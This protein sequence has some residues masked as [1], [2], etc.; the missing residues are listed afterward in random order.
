MKKFLSEP[1]IHFL[2]IGVLLFLGFSF[3]QK[4]DQSM[5]ATI[6]ITDN[7][8]NLLM[9]DF[10]RTW[11]RPP[12]EKELQGLL[13]EKIRE[14]IAYREGLALGLDRDDPYIRRRLRMKLELMLED[15]SAQGEVTDEQLEGFL[16]ENRPSFRQEPRLRFSQIY[17]NPDTRAGTLESD[18][19]DLLIRLRQMGD[20]LNL[21][22]FGDSIML[23][24]TF[25][26][27]SESVINRQFGSD[28]TEQLGRLEVGT[29]QGPVPSGYGIHLVLVEERSEGRDPELAE[30]RPQVERE[31]E[32]KQRQE[33]KEKIYSN[34]REKYTVEIETDKS[35]E[36]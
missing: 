1:L 13:E 17:L 2:I 4:E 35:S 18:A 3:F 11:Q 28:F 23:P 30:I 31:Y 36:S 16:A 8:I 10:E 12:R 34:L 27:A 19:K 21:E 32:L 15:I 9:A 33:L 6:V 20:D 5:D 14:E 26:L 24:T 25:P 22:Q 29:W 7:D